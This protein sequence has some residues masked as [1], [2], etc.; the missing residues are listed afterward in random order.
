MNIKLPKLDNRLMIIHQIGMNHA[1]K[2]KKWVF[3]WW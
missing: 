3:Y 2:F 1:C